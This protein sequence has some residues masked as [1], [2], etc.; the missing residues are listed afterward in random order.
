METRWLYTTSENFPALREASKETC[1]IPMGCVEKHGLHLPLGTDIITVSRRAWMASQLETVCVFPDFTFGD[2]P[3]TNPKRPE[4]TIMMPIEL[5]MAML[6]HF[7]E[8]IARNGFKKIV[9][10]NGH[11]GNRALLSTFQRKIEGIPHNYVLTVLHTKAHVPHI[12]GKKILEEGSG[13]IPELTLEDE[14]LIVKYHKMN[15]K[16]GHAC[17]SETARMMGIAPEC[18]HLDRLGIEDGHSLE[19]TQ[20]FSDAGLSLASEGW[21]YNYPNWFDGDDPYGC[22]ERIGKATL[23]MEAEWAANAFKVLKEDKDLIRWHNEKWDTNL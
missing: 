2:I 9:I 7:C 1:V 16:L 19:L 5:E 8:Q 4:G 22:N 13:C 14:E 6:E 3:T 17:F 11:G 12:M 18:V 20:K 15:M 21:G 23:R 10:Y